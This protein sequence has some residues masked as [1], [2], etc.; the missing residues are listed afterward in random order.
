MESIRISDRI[1]YIPATEKP[2][3]ADV[4]I[5]EGDNAIYFFDVGSDEKVAEFIENYDTGLNSKSERKKKIAVISHFHTDHTANLTRTRF[6]KI[7]LG[8]LT[9]KYFSIM[10]DS[11]NLH[12]VSNFEAP[13]I[14]TENATPF[15]EICEIVSSPIEI[16]D[17]I[18]ITIAEI[19]SSHSKSSVYMQVGDYVFLGDATFYGYKREK[20]FYNAQVLQAEIK[21]LKEIKAEHFMLSH[22][23]HFVKQKRSVLSLLEQIYKSKK[24]NQNEIEIF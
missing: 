23:R 13:K 10:R 15:E 16:D 9:M 19:P 22:R 24:E 5:V 17:G 4:G 21:V 3:S 8:K 18:K 1:S 11:Q 20:K 7:Y 14:S 2:F 12:E 6:D